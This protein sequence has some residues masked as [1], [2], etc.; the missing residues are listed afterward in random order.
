MELFK[1]FLFTCPP[2][3]KKFTNN[4][5]FVKGNVL[6]NFVSDCSNLLLIKNKT[7]C[8]SRLFFNERVKILNIIFIFLCLLC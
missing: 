1:L 3:S 6:A 2:L 8:I 5:S 4:V 7:K